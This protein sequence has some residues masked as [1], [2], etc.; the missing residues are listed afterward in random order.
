MEETE[1]KR[2]LLNKRLFGDET[3][4]QSVS[5]GIG[6]CGTLTYLSAVV[7]RISNTIEKESVTRSVARIYYFFYDFFYYLIFGSN[8]TW[9]VD[10]SRCPQFFLV[11]ELSVG[12]GCCLGGSWRWPVYSRKSLFGIIYYSL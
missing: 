7:S 3:K 11:M 12:D 10:K 4:N 8:K 5:S 6:K 9:I 1:L 2:V